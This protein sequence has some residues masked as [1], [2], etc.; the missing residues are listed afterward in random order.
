MLPHSPQCWLVTVSIVSG[1]P[2][3]FR[4]QIATLNGG[5]GISV[6]KN[7]VANSYS[8]RKQWSLKRWLQ[9]LEQ[10]RSLSLTRG[11]FLFS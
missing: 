3:E 1:L 11:S 10:D 9:L 5:K 4:P 6:K 8:C 2:F 7:M